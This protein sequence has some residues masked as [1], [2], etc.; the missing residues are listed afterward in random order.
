MNKRRSKEELER[1]L[2]TVVRGKHWTIIMEYLQTRQETVSSRLMTEQHPHELFRLQGQAKELDHLLNL[3][4]SYAN[5][6]A[7]KKNA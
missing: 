3:R 1:Q 5:R 4:Q 6:E 7:V 2:E